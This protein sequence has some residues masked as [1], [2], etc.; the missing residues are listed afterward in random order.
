MTC[1]C[2]D[3]PMKD[4]PVHAPEESNSFLADHE[5]RLRSLEALVA[6]LRSV[7]LSGTLA[8]TPST[9]LAEGERLYNPEAPK[10]TAEQ[11]PTSGALSRDVTAGRDRRFEPAPPPVEA[12]GEEKLGIEYDVRLKRLV[13]QHD[14]VVELLADRNYWKRMAQGLEQLSDTYRTKLETAERERDELRAKLTEYATQLDSER[15]QMAQCRIER[16]SALSEL[17]KARAVVDA[18]KRYM[19]Y[20]PS[21][22]SDVELQDMLTAALRA[23]DGK[24]EKNG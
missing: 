4:C 23:F 18:T 14:I 5:R 24:G 17:D 13:E 6:E 12:E 21:D 15:E 16:D 19:G 20:E 8:E 7:Y 22:Y 10:A 11:A 3:T 9:R 2:H 1:T